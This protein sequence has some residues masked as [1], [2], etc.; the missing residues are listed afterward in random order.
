MDLGACTDH[1]TGQASSPTGRSC[2]MG[3]AASGVEAGRGA[4]LAPDGAPG[5]TPPIAVIVADRP[6]LLATPRGRGHP[7]PWP[8]VLVLGGAEGGLIYARAVLPQL[9]AAGV[10]ALGLAYVAP[11]QPAAIAAE[12]GPE[13][14]ETRAGATPS[15]VLP[16]RLVEIPLEPFATA[17]QWL[18]QQ[19]SV[20]DCP[21]VVLGASKGAEAAL[22][23]ASLWP[24]RVT[25]AIAFAPSSVIWQGIGVDA[26]GQVRSSWQRAGRTLPFLALPLDEV[27]AADLRQP[28]VVWHRRALAG[29]GADGAYRIPVE[30]LRAEVLLVSGGDDAMW[31]AAAMSEA[32]KGRLQGAAAL[33][34]RHVNVPDAGHR[35][36][37]P[38]SAERVRA[39]ADDQ[40][41]FGGTSEADARARR[42]GWQASTE[43]LS[44][45]A[46]RC[47]GER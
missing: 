1:G 42:L 45:L 10:V 15:V 7:G 13:R 47:S 5:S 38:P 27:F 31:P 4:R 2:G 36:A 12:S 39:A 32:I 40:R 23:V 9:A 19:P 25:A 21:R 35:I 46:R 18:G 3:L 37:R 8:G 34:V 44:R 24:E 16:K 20:G 11:A 30:R 22:L 28:M 17:L 33:R 6:G 26:Q 29:A 41:A 14:R 43:L